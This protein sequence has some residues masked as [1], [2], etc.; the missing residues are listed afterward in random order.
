MAAVMRAFKEESGKSLS[1]LS[2]ELEISRSALQDYLSGT[3]N[4]NVAT[5]SHL[6]QKLGV[7][8]AFLVSGSFPD[9]QF[10]ILMKLLDSFKLLF[11][12]PKERRMR[13]AELLLEMVKLLSGDDG[14]G[15]I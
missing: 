3:G 10:E 4:P 9:G 14:N 8:E 11:E 13:F 7:D 15:Q 1:E 5:I 12:L 2:A 6:A